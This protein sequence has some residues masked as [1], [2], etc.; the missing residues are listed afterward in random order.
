MP[1]G[2]SYGSDGRLCKISRE[3]GSDDPG[4]GKFHHFFVRFGS[5]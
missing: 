4:A 5:R 3:D 2:D 1:S